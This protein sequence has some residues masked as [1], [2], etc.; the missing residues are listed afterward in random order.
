MTE[1]S[2][3]RK[4]TAILCADVKGYS[5]MMG[6]DEVGTF[7]TLSDYLEIMTTIISEHNGRVFSSPGDAILAQFRSAVDAVE[8]AVEIQQ[9]IEAK[10]TD[11]PEDRK[12]RFRIG[13]NIG[14]VI[15]KKDRIYGD[16]VNIAARIETLAE[17]GG[18]S[19][20]KTVY[21]HV[22]NK[23]KFG[24]E[25]Q[26]EYEVKNIVKPVTI[27]KVLTA[28]EHAGQ[29]IGEPKASKHLSKQS[30]IS[31]FSV[32]A[33]VVAAAIW[34]FYP[35]TP[36]IEPALVEKMAFPL[37]DKPSIAVLPFDN[38]SGYPEHD[39]I[40]DGISENIISALSYIPEL[41]V[42]ARNSSFTYKGKPIKVQQVSE[43]LGVQY[44]LEGSVLKS[45]EK[46]RITVQLIDALTGGHIWSERYNR[47]LNDLFNTLDEITFKMAAALQVKLI[48]EEHAR[49]HITDNLDAWRYV[50]K[51]SGIFLKFGK[52]AMIKSR[53]LFQK[54]LE[55]DPEFAGAVTFLAWTHFIDARFG[56]S[57]SRRESFERAV[58]L[59]NKSLTMD[60]NEP[61]THDLLSFIY[62][63][64]KQYE[65]SIK[66]GRKSIALGPNRATGHILF[67]EILYRLGYFEESVQ[68]CERAI[69]LQ[70]HT[71]LYY[72]GHMMTA[73]YWV[74]RHKESL[75]MA[76]ILINKG[77]ESGAKVL[78][79]WGYWGAIR[80][81][82]KLGRES[83]ARK[84]VAKKLEITPGHSLESERRSTLYKPEMFEQEYEVM[85]KAGYP[86]QS[87]SHFSDNMSDDPEQEYFS[88]EITRSIR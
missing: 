40:A 19:I 48:G 79:A 45:G 69:R 81:K 57:D 8:C 38:M 11:I 72:F 54:A 24:Y 87:S 64:K 20:S 30:Y 56:Y 77:R 12:M 34:Y 80:A 51:G 37:P 6:E 86:E 10:N 47:D 29:I 82:V 59:A 39:Y 58:E 23:L 7:H 27:Y 41:F 28:P 70:P 88:G 17:P 52:E 61:F 73:Y 3:K 9:K 1:D 5:R 14:D 32:I 62:L 49:V 22:Q 36:E 55:I 71:P 75:A 43:E 2:V 33:L 15:E 63:I 68:M 66:E 13:I 25:Y 67:G 21:N 83:E 35:R 46:I 18:V 42:I 44:V 16:G 76:E 4:L 60:D 31:I 84:D 74:G 85:R 26:G 78:E 50:T 65:K 53:E